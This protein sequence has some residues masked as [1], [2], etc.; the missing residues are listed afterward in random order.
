MV[1]IIIAAMSKADRATI[2]AEAHKLAQSG[3]SFRQIERH[4]R[5]KHLGAVTVLK[6][7]WLR[8]QLRLESQGRSVFD[9]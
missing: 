3:M 4:L 6:D 5:A 1:A 8:Q 2:E 7:E 9:A